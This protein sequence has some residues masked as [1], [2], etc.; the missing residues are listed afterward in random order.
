M[1]CPG[2]GFSIRAREAAGGVCLTLA[3]ALWP[4]VSWAQNEVK[5]S[6]AQARNLG[7]RE[8]HPVPVRTDLT[9]P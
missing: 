9:L 3:F 8:S 2:I 5:L 6:D 4:A 1:H 7:V